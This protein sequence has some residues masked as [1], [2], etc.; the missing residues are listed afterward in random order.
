M[1]SAS[2]SPKSSFRQL[3]VVVNSA[4]HHALFSQISQELTKRGLPRDGPAK[5]SQFDFSQPQF[6]PIYKTMV[7]VT[8]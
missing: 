2:F 1:I 4:T 5:A 8:G 6:P 3:S 7:K